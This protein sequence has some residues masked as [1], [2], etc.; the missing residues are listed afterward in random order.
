MFSVK[1]DSEAT[2]QLLGRVRAGEQVAFEELFARH[3]P[4]LRQLIEM[5][6]DARLRAR[7]DPSDVVQETQMEAFRRL[8]DFLQREPMPFRLWLR[9]AAQERIGMIERQHLGASK[10]A[11]GRELPLPDGSSVLLAQ[12]LAAPIPSPSQQVAQEEMARRV[13]EAVGRLPDQDREILLMRTFEGLAYEEV[14]CVLEIDPAT[15][16]K[17]HGRALIRLHALLTA[18]G[19][20]DSQR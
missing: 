16:R 15:A 6:L 4:L 2:C 12:Q 18:D 10:R 20:S 19:L 9:K 1:P 7:V 3:R 14:S 17:R 8:Q 5:R 11:V 13:R